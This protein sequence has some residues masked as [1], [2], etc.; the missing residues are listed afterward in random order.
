MKKW[1]F[2]NVFIKKVEIQNEIDRLDIKSFTQGNKTITFEVNIFI[3]QK[4]AN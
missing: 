2:T 1:V 3:K 4:S